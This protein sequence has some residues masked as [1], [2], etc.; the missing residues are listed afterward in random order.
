MRNRTSVESVG[1]TGDFFLLNLEELIIQKETDN[2]GKEEL[3][4]ANIMGRG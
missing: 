3:P 1:T 2:T 4:T